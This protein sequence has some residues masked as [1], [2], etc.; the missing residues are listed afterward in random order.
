[1]QLAISI[2]IQR[3]R[4]VYEERTNSAPLA[5]VILGQFSHAYPL[6]IDLDAFERFACIL[7]RMVHGELTRHYN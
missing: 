3:T 1:M 4:K 2:C 7:A 5:R 6:Q